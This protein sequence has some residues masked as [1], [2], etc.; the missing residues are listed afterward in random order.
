MEQIDLKLKI[1]ERTPAAAEFDR[2]AHWIVVVPPGELPRRL[3][4]AA[5]LR[6]RMQRTARKDSDSEPFVTQLPDAVG[7]RVALAR[8]RADLAQFDLLTLAR[9]LVVAH[10][11]QRAAELHVLIAGF[12]AAQRER[13]AEALYAAALAAAAAMPS[14]RRKTEQP[15]LRAL[16]LHGGPDSPRFARTRAEAEGNALARRLT[17][18]PSNHLTPADYLKQVRALARRHG[19]RLVF[20]DLRALRRLGAGAFC[21]VA[22]GSPEPDAG[23]VH[24]RY[25]PRG[26]GGAPVALVGKGICFDTGGVNLK[27]G[28]YMYGMHGDMQ[29]S[30][31]ALGILHALTR[32]RV[33]FPVDCW[34]ALAMN[35]IGPRAYKPNDVVTTVNGVSIEVVDTDAEGRMVLSDTLA[36]AARRRP[37]LILDFATLTGACKRALGNGM[38]GVFTNRELWVQRLIETGRQSGERVWPF[39]LDEDYDQA[40]ESEIADVKQCASEPGPDHIHAARF[41]GRFVGDV[42]WI[43][44]DL[45]AGGHKGGLGHVPTTKTGFGV[46]FTLNLLLDQELV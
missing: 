17:V 36:L 44:M 14:Y 6:Q 12:T 10:A 11:A 1:H 41:L 42:P 40:L 9:K 16:H 24:L 31:V 29:G 13:I 22:Q 25:A 18:L 28:Q 8:V 27:T 19:W 5:L 45:S 2:A 15:A 3:P 37:R 21:A 39:P 38:S 30:A 43:H 7:T 35:H 33:R 4:H 34:L 46:R 32:L 20:H 23:I 26:R